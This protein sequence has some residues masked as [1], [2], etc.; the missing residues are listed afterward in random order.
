MR[1]FVDSVEAQEVVL[2]ER[3]TFLVISHATAVSQPPGSMDPQRFE[4]ISNIVKQ[5][6]LSCAKIQ[7]QFTAFELRTTLFS[8]FITPY[9]S[10]T[11]V[12]VIINDPTIRMSSSLLIL[13]Q[14]DS[15]TTLLNIQIAKSRFD[16]EQA[17]LPPTSQG[18]LPAK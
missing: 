3:T 1:S 16:Q 12:M 9:T 17:Q 13:T 18:T 14:L 10:D 6:K 5:F 7:S 15:A 11:Y 4:K 8:A 2:F